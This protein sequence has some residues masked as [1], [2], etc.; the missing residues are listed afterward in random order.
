MNEGHS[1]D[2]L[3]TTAAKSIMN[4]RLAENIYGYRSEVMYTG[5]SKYNEE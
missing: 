4:Y 3:Y 2:I 5:L 1:E